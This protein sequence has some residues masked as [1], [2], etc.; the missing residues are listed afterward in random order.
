MDD[1]SIP[2]EIITK[3]SE[4]LTSHET[5]S[6]TVKTIVM[7]DLVGSTSM[8]LKKGHDVAM[9][10]IRFHNCMC[11]NVIENFGGFV[12]K[13]L[14]DGI[15]AAFDD[16]FVACQTAINIRD[17]LRSQKHST[18][19][20]LVYGS[21]EKQ[22]TSGVDDYF[23]STIDFCA[24]IEKFAQPN[25]ILIDEKLFGLIQTFSS[26]KDIIIGNSLSSI[27]EKN[28][29]KLY[30][31]TSKKMK[32]LNR[33]NL[34]LKIETKG[35]LSLKDHLTFI[36][37]AKSEIIE[38]GD[39]FEDFIEYLNDTRINEFRTPIKKLLSRGISF[40][41]LLMDPKWVHLTFSDKKKRDEKVEKIY[42]ALDILKSFKNECKREQLSGKI[43]LRL[44]HNLSSIFTICIDPKNNHGKL[45][46]LHRVYGISKNAEPILQFSKEENP[47]LFEIYM[48]SVE[49]LRKESRIWR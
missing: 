49:K 13:E 10:S 18:K 23:G 9:K 40:T 19:I 44:Y 36:E 4:H 38:L 5:S 6:P 17:S 30:E 11:R 29:V 22:K 48:I 33:L 12:I 1:F 7:F 26:S 46:V 37:S 14:G 15:L 42:A 20:S 16:P 39:D 31:I 3:C 43:E 34:P 27:I 25:Q 35:V 24:K 45:N 2:Q 32:L 41:F 21:V 28:E 47:D 8:K